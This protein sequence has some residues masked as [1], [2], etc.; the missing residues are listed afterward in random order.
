METAVNISVSHILVWV[1]IETKHDS[2]LEFVLRD[3]ALRSGKDEAYYEQ[4]LVDLVHAAL[5][6]YKDIGLAETTTYGSLS[7]CITVPSWKAWEEIA[8]PIVANKV[9]VWKHRYRI[10]KMK[11]DE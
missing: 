5:R 3:T 6:P 10:D 9:G 1:W 8:A 7:L 4:Q 11:E 2:R